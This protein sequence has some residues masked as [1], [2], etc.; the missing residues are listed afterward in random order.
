MFT[1]PW[2]V[3]DRKIGLGIA[4]CA[5][6]V[7]L[8]NAT[9]FLH[10]ADEFAIWWNILAVCVVVLPLV[11]AVGW[12][13]LP[14]SALRALWITQPFL[15]L[16]T[17]LLTYLAWEGGAAVLP[18]PQGWLLD[19]TILAAMAL[20]VRLP[21]VL[22][23]MLAL[24][25]VVPLSALIFLGTIPTLVL[26]WGFVHASNII[27][28]MLALVLREQMNSLHRARAT[29]AQ[30]QAE[31]E[32]IRGEFEAFEGF[33]R[34][35]HDEVLATFAAALQFSGEPPPLLRQS[36]ATALQAL[37][38]DQRERS[39]EP[40]ELSGEDAVQLI[41]DLIGAAAPGVELTSSHASSTVSSA[42]ASAVGLAAAEAARN[43]S[44]HAGGGTGVVLVGDGSI[45]VTIID[46]GPGFD[47]ATVT[48][49]HFGI[50]DSII[51][52]VEELDQ[53]KVAFDSGPG[54]TTVVMR[55]NRPP[56]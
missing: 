37:A 22:A 11:A 45:R 54:G 4:V 16:I 53:G 3:V 36:A 49:G 26:S 21:Y 9:G 18:S 6:A 41:R 55:W 17:L 10:R 29:A 46:A 1:K 27:Y 8:F 52:R 28:V 24:A 25:A 31:G 13:R 5:L 43:A 20:V 33:A 39:P 2:S 50:R 15:L 35:V 7:A 48:A 30:L 23:M 44:R 32:R 14:A 34:T 40:I 38:R 42:A 19:A 56:G 51:R 47:L 12:S